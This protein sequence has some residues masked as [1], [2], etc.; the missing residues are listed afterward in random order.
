MTDALL[1]LAA[2]GEAPAE[3]VLEIAGAPAHF[4]ELEVLRR[5]D[6]RRLVLKGRLLEGPASI[7]AQ[8]S[9]SE[10]VLKVF[11]GPGHGRYFEREA[12]GLERLLAAGVATP[13]CYY[14][15]NEGEVSVLLLEY[16]AGSSPVHAADDRAVAGVAELLGRLHQTGCSHG[17]LHLDNF[18]VARGTVFAI[19]G[20]GVVAGAAPGSATALDNL[21]VLAAQRPPACDD[22]LAPL[23]AAYG[24]GSDHPAPTVEAFQPRLDRARRQ[25]LRRYARKTQR[26]CSE[27]SVRRAAGRTTLAVRDGGEQLLDAL[28]G[29][30]RLVPDKAFLELEALKEGR[31]AT[32]VRALEGTGAVVK[33]FNVK[34]PIHRL[35]RSLRPMPRYRR[36]WIFG[37]LLH[38]QAIPTARPL[39]LVE[40]HQG[41]IRDVAYLIMEDIGGRTIG[42]EVAEEGL[43]DDRIAD[44]C[45][46]FSLLRRVGFTHGDTK[47]TNFIL[48]EN[49]LHLI[50]LDA[51]RFAPRGTV[52]G[53]FAE[54]RFR[55]DLLR[56]LE[57]WADPE[58]Q[59][60]RRA[61]S[62]AGL[63]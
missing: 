50:D 51:M 56:F 40:T 45:A 48:Y 38:F 44:T 10:V 41:G 43:S 57:N 3:L 53:P 25:R 63:L 59:R 60:F 17:D 42:D 46:L 27:F 18:L 8:L 28:E 5:L 1:A 13:A 39:A 14:S 22:G 19:D 49:R 31:S 61:F 36:A 15:G 23:L 30:G 26:P 24:A 54:R 4:R 62:R 2:G 12:A 35:R 6:G 7:D 58:Q 11:L 34:D 37:Q 29:A 16:L 33:R 21:A 20:D 52:A 9:A 55:A 32:V 47:A